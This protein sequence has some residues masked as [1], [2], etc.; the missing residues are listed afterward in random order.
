MTKTFMDAIEL[1]EKESTQA[2][3]QNALSGIQSH[4]QRLI[5]E[6]LNKHRRFNVRHFE[7]AREYASNYGEP[8][9][10]VGL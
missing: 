3:K 8:F 1:C 9:H 2:G 10:L 7:P 4:H 5:H 6:A